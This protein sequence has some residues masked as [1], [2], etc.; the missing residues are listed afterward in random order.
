MVKG[1]LYVGTGYRVCAM[2]VVKGLN[3]VGLIRIRDRL[4]VV[5][6]PNLLSELTYTVGME[7]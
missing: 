3:I 4:E 2:E 5:K 7:R 1:L 6:R